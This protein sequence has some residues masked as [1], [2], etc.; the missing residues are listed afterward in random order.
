MSSLQE[1]YQRAKENEALISKLEA[2]VAELEKNKTAKSSG[3]AWAE[4]DQVLNTLKKELLPE[5]KRLEA[6]NAALKVENGKLKQQSSKKSSGSTSDQKKD[7]SDIKKRLIAFRS[8]VKALEDEN[9]DL[10]KK[11]SARPSGSDLSA[12][13]REAVLE[14]LKKLRPAVEKL[15]QE[16]QALEAKLAAL[17]QAPQAES[18]A[19]AA[20]AGMVQQSM[21]SIVEMELY[22]V[23]GSMKELKATWAEAELGPL[24]D[25]DFELY[26][27]RDV[28]ALELEDDDDTINC[29]F[30][31]HSTQWFPVS[32]LYKKTAAPAAPAAPASAKVLT[33]EDVSLMELYY[34]TNCMSTLKS[35]WAEAELG[36]LDD[37][38]F[39]LYLGRDVTAL[40]LEDDDDTINCRFDNHETQWFPVS[41]L[42]VEKPGAAASSQFNVGMTQLTKIDD[43]VEMEI[44]YVTGDIEAL[45]KEWAAAEL[46]PLDDE[47]FEM[48]LNR[49]VKALE[50]EDD[51]DTVQVR[52][53]NHSTQWFPV[54][55]LYSK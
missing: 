20:A 31:N 21:D 7:Y 26:L 10:K 5:V 44:Y 45:K 16:K 13:K 36:P 12:G 29:R 19:P 23:T 52:F 54:T 51:D 34:V 53:D 1:F 55:V 35:A 30:D 43:A 25:E 40:E 4:K 24:D 22:Y 18:S 15:E 42:S 32:C 33:L 9:A 28:T 38:D 6:E 41:V 17:T 37:E 11:V 39:E 46:G 47:D 2:R 3:K 49:E 8:K 50:I 14:R 48:Y 27:N